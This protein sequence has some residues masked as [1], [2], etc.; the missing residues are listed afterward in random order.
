MQMEVTFEAQPLA[1]LHQRGEK[2]EWCLK[3]ESMDMT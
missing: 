1:S 2:K 3:K